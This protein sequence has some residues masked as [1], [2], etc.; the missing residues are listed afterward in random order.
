MNIGYGNGNIYCGANLLMLIWGDPGAFRRTIEA[1]QRLR[2]RN[3]RDPE[4]A[5][6][7]ERGDIYIVIG[8]IVGLIVGGALGIF[9][10]PL[11]IFGG[12]IGGGIIGAVVGGLIKKRKIKTKNTQKPF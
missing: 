10:G 3:E 9:G 11:G 7:P 2:D 5:P 1:E 8:T 6:K 12:F 4:Q